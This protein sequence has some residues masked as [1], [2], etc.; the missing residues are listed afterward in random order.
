MSKSMHP[1]GHGRIP[2]SFSERVVGIQFVEHANCAFPDLKP[3]FG[4]CTSLLMRHAGLGFEQNS[5]LFV[6]RSGNFGHKNVQKLCS[7]VS[8][9]PVMPTFWSMVHPDRWATTG[10]SALGD[11]ACGLLLMICQSGPDVPKLSPKTAPR[12]QLSADIR[13]RRFFGRRILR[14]IRQ[15]A[16]FAGARGCTE[17]KRRTLRPR[18]LCRRSCDSGAFE[19]L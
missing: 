2:N 18:N 15:R 16:G 1:H 8:R 19:S 11:D 7:K 10:E 4:G 6:Q 17:T 3:D 14:G 12:K 13:P 5:P 9:V